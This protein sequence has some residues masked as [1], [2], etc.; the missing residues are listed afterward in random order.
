[1]GKYLIY[2][3]LAI[4]IGVIGYASWEIMHSK[5]EANETYEEAKK[6]IEE[7]VIEKKRE[8]FVPEQGEVVG[9]LTI[10]KIDADLAIIE[11]TDPDELGKGVGHYKGAYYPDENGQIVLSGHR[12]TVFK[13]IGELEIGDEMKVEVPYGDYSYKIKHTEIV[14]ANDMTII[15]LQNDEEELIVT[16]CYPFGYIGDAPYR[17]IIYAERM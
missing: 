15:T 6:V 17:Y 11:G 16:T 9:L 14:D 1:M 8:R 2:L 12:D 5:A 4:G 13:H 3:I 7:P 10:P